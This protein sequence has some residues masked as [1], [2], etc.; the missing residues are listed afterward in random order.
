MCNNTSSP[1]RTAKTTRGI[2]SKHIIVIDQ[3]TTSTRAV[4]FNELGQAQAQ[5]Q[6]SLHQYY[7]Q[8]GW[9]EHSPEEIWQATLSCIE[10]V[11][12]KSTLAAAKISC[13]GITNQRETT[14]IWN[15]HTGK[16]IYNAIVWQDRRTAEFCRAHQD[17]EKMLQQKTGL[18]LDPYFSATKIKWILENTDYKVED[19][20]FGTI[21]TFLLWRLTKGKSHFTDI[22]NA[23][24]TALFN[25]QTK[26]WDKELLE[27]FNVPASILPS[28]QPNVAD[29]GYCD[30]SY[31]GA[32]IPITA[33][34]GDQQSAAIGQACIHPGMV[35]STYGTGCFMLMNTGSLLIQSRHRLLSTIAFQI[36]NQLSYAIEGSIFIAGAAIQWLRDNLKIIDSSQESALLAERI[37][38]NGG[39]YFV[40]A[41]TGLG[42]PH[43]QPDVRGTIFGI[44]RDT[45]RA[46]IIRAALEGVCYE[47]K[48]LIEAIEKDGVKN[49]ETI[50]VD[51]GMVK[52]EW[53][54]QFLADIVGLPV[55]R[56]ENIESTALGAAFLAGLGAGIYHSLNDVNH[57]WRGQEKHQPTMSQEKQ[58][59]LYGQWR[60][61]IEMLTSIQ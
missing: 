23:S 37:E 27:L 36:N 10:K 30:P 20:L 60:R 24:R 46:H 57:I 28:V 15:K 17:K 38:D 39:V 59:Q 19:L 5:H 14:I 29:F 48:D 12:A 42:A 13:I 49:I 11:L 25:L 32:E 52:N 40:P 61:Y 3:G 7:P 53:M 47:T 34:I 33:M 6:I 1:V 4:L 58:H 54:L 43:W 55:E 22:T 8:L 41:F 44:T 2:M 21:D 45:R 56:A 50:R 35:K 18:V 9:V 31:F 51:G 16:P 26:Q